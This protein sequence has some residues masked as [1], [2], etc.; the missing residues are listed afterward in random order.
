M[1]SKMKQL[2]KYGFWG[3]ISTGI[4]LLLFYLFIKIKIPYIAANVVSYIIAVIASYFFNNKYVFDAHESDAKES[5]KQIKY[6]A[7]RGIS[8]AVDSALLAFLHELCGLN[9]VLSKVLDSII[10]IGATY[11]LSKFWIFEGIK[12]ND[13]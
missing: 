8:V 10:I 4:N 5:T 7:M 3:V 9:L 2:I 13:D 1:I 11:I 6:F 12:K